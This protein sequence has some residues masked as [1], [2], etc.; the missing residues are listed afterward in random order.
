MTVRKFLL[1]SKKNRYG[2][3]GQHGLAPGQL[4]VSTVNWWNFNRFSQ[5]FYCWKN[6]K[7]NHKRLENFFRS[8]LER[9][10]GAV[11]FA[12]VS[13]CARTSPLEA[14]QLQMLFR[15]ADNGWLMNSVPTS[16]KKHRLVVE[17]ESL[18]LSL[19]KNTTRR[20]EDG[21]YFKKSTNM[22]EK[23]LR[24]IYSNNVH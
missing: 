6:I 16:S 4:T 23:F 13:S 18:V 22:W 1:K 24:V 15:D 12:S 3:Y 19:I 17:V 2:Q 21:E 11:Q 20:R 14:F 10:M 5:F 9:F 8:S 7:R